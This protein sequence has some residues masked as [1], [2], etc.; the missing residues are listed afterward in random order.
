MMVDDK[1]MIVSIGYSK[2]WY[3]GFA[4]WR[5]KN[6][7]NIYFIPLI[8]L[9]QGGHAGWGGQNNSDGPGDSYMLQVRGTNQLN[10]KAVQVS[11]YLQ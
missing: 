3:S 7:L 10:T 9:F 1:K 2:I 5:F 6:V 11:T 4:D 8:C